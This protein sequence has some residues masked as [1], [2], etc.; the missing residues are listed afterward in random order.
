MTFRNQ[1]TMDI[2]LTDHPLRFAITEEMHLRKIPRFNSPAA[3][4]Q[5]VM[6]S[7]EDGAQ[8]DRQHAEALCERFAA[9]QPRSGKYFTARLAHLHFVWER[10]TEVSTY[11]FIREGRT[12]SLLDDTL[13]RELP[14]EWVSAMPGSVLRA[15][16]VAVVRAEEVSMDELE[17][18]F[19]PDDLV[20]C[21]VEMG[22]ARIC[23]DFKLHADGFGRLVII[24][25]GLRGNESARLLQRL[26]EL[27]NYRNMALLGLPVAQSFSAKLSQLEQD[28]ATLTHKIAS[29]D[30]DDG[31]VLDEITRLA[32]EL[33]RITAETNYRMSASRAYAELCYERLS[34]LH[35]T[36]VDGYQTL[37]DFTE[38]RFSPAVR[39]CES[40]SRRLSDLLQRTLWTSSLLRTRVETRLEVQSHD[41]LA[42]MNRRTD[43]QLRLQQTVE[44]LSVAAIS[45]YV[46]GLLRYM[47][48]PLEPLIPAWA[49]RTLLSITGILAVILVVW[50]TVRRIRKHIQVTD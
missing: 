16:R 3:V 37:T 28:L 36:S 43:L 30:T 35:V 32:A 50:L 19:P 34:A 17:R 2:G 26:Q 5:F 10:H 33:A 12:E 11:T 38:R 31:D 29:S 45:Y 49:P 18:R 42:S 48:E 47:F 8:R 15:T 14:S 24:D 21:E 46:V 6:L 39:T 13:L 4:L 20:L 23:S 44:G 27:G 22:R 25:R 41:L 7:G 40:F 9:P 1:T